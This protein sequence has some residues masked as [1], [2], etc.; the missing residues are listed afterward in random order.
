MRMSRF[1]F[2]WFCLAALFS[3][4]LTVQLSAQT[5]P[6][7]PPKQSNLQ[8]SVAM[9]DKAKMSITIKTSSVN[10]EVIYSADTKFLVGHSNNN[11]PGSVD[12]V[13]ESYFISCSGTYNA[14]NVQLMAKEC[15]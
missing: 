9:M 15:V 1:V 13:K 14:G 3:L 6:P 4:M 2:R 11:K 12:Q 5:K 8:G 7:K 10:R